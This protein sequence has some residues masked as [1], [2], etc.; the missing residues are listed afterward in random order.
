MKYQIILRRYLQNEGGFFRCVFK[1]SKVDILNP[2]NP[3]AN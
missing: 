2:F 1:I 3:E